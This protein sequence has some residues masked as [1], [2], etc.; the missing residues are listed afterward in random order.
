MTDEKTPAE[1]RAEEESLGLPPESLSEEITL[2]PPE[3][4]D[5]GG[6]SLDDLGAGELTATYLSR[7]D[8]LKERQ[9]SFASRAQGVGGV[10]RDPVGM[11]KYQRE[12]A[13]E[14]LG[15]DAWPDIDELRRGLKFV[16]GVGDEASSQIAFEQGAFGLPEGVT[17]QQLQTFT[18]AAASPLSG[19]QRHVG[20]EDIDFRLGDTKDQLG[21]YADAGLPGRFEEP[22]N[23][24]QIRERNYIK[25]VSLGFED[26]NLAEGRALVESLSADP[27]ALFRYQ[28]TMLQAGMYDQAPVMGMAGT[29]DFVAFD[30]LAA[31]SAEAGP[32]VGVDEIL[33]AGRINNYAVVKDQRNRAQAQALSDAS[34]EIDSETRI[35][36]EADRWFE[37]LMGLDKRAMAPELRSQIIAN[38]RAKQTENARLRFKDGLESRLDA[39]GRSVNEQQRTIDDILGVIE[40]S[41]NSEISRDSWGHWS[42]AV[43]QTYMPRNEQNQQ[44]VRESIINNYLQLFNGDVSTVFRAWAG[45]THTPMIDGGNYGSVRSEQFADNSMRAYNEQLQADRDVL[46]G[47][48]DIPSLRI[49]D[50][51]NLED[52]IRAA[53]EADDP[54]RVEALDFAQKANITRW[55]QMLGRISS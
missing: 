45:D 18:S 33:E 51:Y 48:G 54:G 50:S 47:E 53:V 42:E 30:R 37:N 10:T 7:V 13:L 36:N 29:N 5:F 39:Q 35:G 46:D 20:F 25:W 15:Y 52:E 26:L 8:R 4:I 23:V 12:Y 17:P 41:G 24:E 9:D 32:Q 43:F 2:A 31:A 34:A 6:T 1:L 21:R 28:L 55:H 27:D 38:E 3:E 14:Q 44:I 40:A 16:I 22:S 49:Y 19:P 11:S